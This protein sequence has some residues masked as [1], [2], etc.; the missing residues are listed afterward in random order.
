VSRAE[1]D[2]IEEAGGPPA[3]ENKQETESGRAS[4]SAQGEEGDRRAAAWCT[5]RK[6]RKD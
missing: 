2:N 3:G 5:R 4:R 1:G 6:N